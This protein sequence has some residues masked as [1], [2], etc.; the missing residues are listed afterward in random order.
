[1]TPLASLKSL[2]TTALT[3]LADSAKV[4]DYVA[5]IKPAGNAEHGDYQANMAMALAKVLGKKPQDVAKEIIAAISKNEV[6]ESASV[7]GPGFINLKLSTAYLAKSVQA[8]ATDVRLGIPATTSPKKFVIDY[9]SP[10]VAKPLHV[11]HLRSTIIGDTLVR[12]LRFQGHTVLGDNHLGDWGTQFGMLIYGYRTFLDAAAYKTDPVREL[13]RIYVEVRKAIGSEDEEGAKNPVADACRAETAKLHAGNAENFALWQQFMPHCM[14]EIH[15]IYKRL[16]ILPHDHEHGESFYNPMLPGVVDDLLGKGV[17][18]PGDGGAIIVRTGKDQVSLIRKKDG[19]FTY[20]T[21]DLATIQYRVKEFQPDVCLYVVDFRQG[22]H[23]K[24][25]FEV[26]KTWGYKSV[27]LTHISFGSVTGA[28]GK[29]LKTRDGTAVELAGLLDEAEQLGAAKYRESYEDRK[30]HGHAVEEL[31]D[32]QIAEIG[33][34]VGIGAVKYADLSQN[35]TSDYKYDPA[36]MLA[37]DGNTATYMQ[38][39]YAR[40]RSIFRKGDIDDARFRTSPPLPTLALPAERNLA[41]QLLRFGEALDAAAAEYLPHLLTGY[42]WDLAKAYS[43][44]FEQCPVLTA[45]APALKES[46]LLLVDL[47]SRVLRQTLDLLGIGVVERM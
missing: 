13:A 40:A 21:S 14:A 5:M 38:Y 9:S 28:D 12:I 17:A 42:L 16:G 46:R 26:A 34:V 25:L 29:P 36:K 11:G 3:T 22:Q 37:T 20:T 6:I 7:A 10:N 23:F 32:N 24:S 45:E 4:P 18:E 35:R 8:M 15:G 39:A 1:M 2:F 43:Q 44:F 41:L 19:A 31:S 47:V 27:E 30:A 33:R